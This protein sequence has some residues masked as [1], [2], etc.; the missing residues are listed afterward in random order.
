MRR[1][2][3][4]CQHDSASLAGRRFWSGSGSDAA[5]LRRS[6][7]PE[8]AAMCSD[9][10]TQLDSHSKHLVDTAQ[11]FIHTDEVLPYANTSSSVPRCSL[12]LGG[13]EDIAHLFLTLVLL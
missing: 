4:P 2:S 5:R 12:T 13:T 7:A 8:P 1:N 9:L 10:M 11:V 6:S 3:Q